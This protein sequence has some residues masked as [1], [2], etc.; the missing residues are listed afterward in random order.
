MSDFEIILSFTEKL[1]I[2]NYIEHGKNQ[3]IPLN[4][5][6][7]GFISE[8]NKLKNSILF[9][10]YYDIDSIEFPISLNWVGVFV[11]QFDDEPN[12]TVD[13]LFK[14]ENIQNELDSFIQLLSR[15]LAGNLPSFSEIMENRR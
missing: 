7:R 8:N 3:S 4:V 14:N 9:K 11:L 10:V 5:S 12:V 1:N 13:D 6:F 2:S 15:N